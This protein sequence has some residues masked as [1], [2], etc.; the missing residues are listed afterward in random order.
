MSMTDQPP[1]YIGGQRP[2][3]AFCVCTSCGAMVDMQYL[4]QHTEFHGGKA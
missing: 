3:G 1:R 2:F 4:E